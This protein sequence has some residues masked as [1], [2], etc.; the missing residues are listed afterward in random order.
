M[1]VRTRHCCHC[2]CQGQTRPEFECRS[3]VEYCR[4]W[5]ILKEVIFLISSPLANRSLCHPVSFF[6]FSKI[7]YMEPDCVAAKFYCHSWVDH[8]Q[9]Y[10]PLIRSLRIYRS[11][12]F[13]Y[14]SSCN[15]IS[16]L[17]GLL[18]CSRIVLIVNYVVQDGKSNWL[19]GFILMCECSR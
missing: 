7:K 6:F 9:T 11:F 1:A 5:S 14:A 18:T 15:V 10:V 19:E 8:G 17:V 4:S 3:W 16:D 2:F 12:F 13:R